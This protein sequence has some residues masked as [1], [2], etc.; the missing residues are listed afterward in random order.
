MFA[1]GPLTTSALRD[2]RSVFEKV[3]TADTCRRSGPKKAAARRQRGWKQSLVWL[4]SRR[5]SGSRKVRRPC[6]GVTGTAVG[7]SKGAWAWF[8]CASRPAS[9]HARGCLSL[10]RARFFRPPQGMRSRDQRRSVARPQQGW[11]GLP[12]IDVRAYG[13][14]VIGGAPGRGEAGKRQGVGPWMIRAR[15]EFR[16]KE[17]RAQTEAPLAHSG[18]AHEKTSFPGPRWG[19]GASRAYGASFSAPVRGGDLKRPFRRR[20]AGPLRCAAASKVRSALDE[21]GRSN[22]IA[23]QCSK[24]CGSSGS[25]RTRAEGSDK[26]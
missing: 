19:R 5:G 17:Q 18:S 4:D 7:G 21:T 1:V 23:A 8:S 12:G 9:R 3:A 6:R 2:T 10:R 26:R 22:A 13:V 15:A 20:P 24:A 11:A 14:G 16:P 25:G